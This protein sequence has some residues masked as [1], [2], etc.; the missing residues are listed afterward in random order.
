MA[1]ACA[2]YRIASEQ[3]KSLLWLFREKVRSHR[4]SD[5]RHR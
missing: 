1:I 3:L 5:L 2:G 4:L